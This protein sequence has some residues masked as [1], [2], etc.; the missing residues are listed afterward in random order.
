MKVLV[1]IPSYGTRNQPYL[2]R[3]LGEYRAMKHDVHVVVLSDIPR[4]LGPKAEVVVGLPTGDPWSL[5]FAHKQIFA[6]RAG[7]YDLF[8]YSEDDTLIQARH[9]EAFLEATEV[10]P[11]TQIAGFLRYEE[12]A[13]GRRY[14]CTIHSVFH[15]VPASA[16]SAGPWVFAR[17]TNDHA[18]SYILTREQL[19]RAIASGG[20]LVGPHAGR[21]DML[22]SAATDPYTQCGFTKVICISRLDDFLLHH[23]PNRYVGKMGLP[24]DELRAQVDALQRCGREGEAHRELFSTAA[25]LDTVAWDKQY[26]DAPRDNVLENVPREARQV[27]SVGCGAGA[28][29]AVLIERGARVVGI[30]LDAIVAESARIRGVQLTPPD[31]PLAFQRLSG[32]R[33]DCILMIHV[34][35]YVPEPRQLLRTCAQYLVDKGKMVLVIPN[36]RSLAYRLKGTGDRRLWTADDPFR[37]IGIH[38]TTAQMVGRWVV[39]SSLRVRH[40]QYEDGSRFRPLIRT[41]NGLAGPFLSPNLL[42]VIEKA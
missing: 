27:L 10:L 22:C 21:Y 18:A 19:K 42:T 15:W 34:L 9:V 35:Q 7:D 41:C 28:T 26:Y 33:F 4:V 16:A 39:D 25:R 24:F 6:D 1:A 5:P 30:P 37:E 32:A 2:E 12:D 8:I 3:L 29:E 36:F 40:V 20:F 14:C 11:A 23:L 31:F 13:A 38:R 17:L